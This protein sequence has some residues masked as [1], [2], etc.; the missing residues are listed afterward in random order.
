[1][2]ARTALIQA[3]KN[4]WH[5]V[6]HRPEP[7]WAALSIPITL[8]IVIALL[9]SAFSQYVALDWSDWRMWRSAL[10]ENL[11]ISSSVAFTI[12]GA[13][14]LLERLLS[15]AQIEQLNA[16]RGL[17][18]T[19]THGSISVGGVTLGGAL[20]FSL[21]GWFIDVDIWAAL[22]RRPQTIVEFFALSAII[23]ALTSVGWWLYSRRKL[24]SLRASEAQLRLL[25]AQIEP[26]FLFNTL[27]NVHSLMDVDTERARQMLESFTDYLRASLAQ[28][29][30]DDVTL[31]SELASAESY[32][33]LMQ[34]RMAERL[35]FE[36]ETDEELAQLR[37]PPLLLQ[38]LIENAI[39]HGL[40][41]KVEGG[42]VR[43][44]VRQ[45]PG[46]V[47]IEVSD[48]GLGLDAAPRRGSR[49]GNGIALDNI[50]ARL[51]ARYGSAASLLLSPVAGGGTVS[52]LTLPH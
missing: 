35:Q 25:Q 16:D 18:S 21:L 45:Q 37:L 15:A 28:L 49:K 32:L 33:R 24:A 11:I 29:R 5:L 36:I 51:K 26:H 47:V 48:N 10:S 23:I 22:M 2:T 52:R 3:W 50:R 4:N 40:E 9:I 7:L 27:A 1:M 6:K 44:S 43:V 41:P 17:L 42:C 34:C 20:G 39:H 14:R 12:F 8:A 46:R 38:P 31:A 13:Y 30:S 19:L